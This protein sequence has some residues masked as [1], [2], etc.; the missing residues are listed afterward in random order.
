MNSQNVSELNVATTN[1][2]YKTLD[3]L[4]LN[5]PDKLSGLWF[6][7]VLHLQTILCFQISNLFLGKR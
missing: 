2:K 3:A 7:T 6:I 1:S 5:N 4:W